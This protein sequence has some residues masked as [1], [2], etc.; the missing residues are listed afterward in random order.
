MIKVYCQKTNHNS[1]TRQWPK[2]HKKHLILGRS[3]IWITLGTVLY[4]Q[5]ESRTNAQL[6]QD[7]M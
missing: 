2:L 6:L 5:T 3:G 7:V 1:Q 4:T